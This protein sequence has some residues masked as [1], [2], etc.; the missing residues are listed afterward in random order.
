[1]DDDLVREGRLA[2]LEIP[3]RLSGAVRTVAVGYVQSE[4][5]SLIVAARDPAAAWAANLEAAGAATV[6]V[7]DRRMTADA[8]VLEVGDPRRVAGVR[9]L[10]LRYGTPSE[11]LGRGAVFRL[12]P[13]P[14]ASRPASG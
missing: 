3:G 9:D 14:G 2:R 10:I 11:A 12:V 4:D 7:A 1:M 8:E 6:V 13:R 5:G